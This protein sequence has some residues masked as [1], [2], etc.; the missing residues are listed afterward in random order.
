MPASD[1]M[2]IRNGMAARRRLNVS[3]PARKKML[4]DAA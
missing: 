3:P 1:R 2:R 4:S